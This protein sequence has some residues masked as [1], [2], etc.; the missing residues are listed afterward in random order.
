MTTFHTSLSIAIELE[1][2]TF[3]PVTEPDMNKLIWTHLERRLGR[4]ICLE[5]LLGALG[6]NGTDTRITMARLIW[7]PTT[8]IPDEH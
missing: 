7:P 6:F 4:P 3:R 8:R 2:D 1:S 5:T